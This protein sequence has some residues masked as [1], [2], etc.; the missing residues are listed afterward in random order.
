[1][2]R[3][4]QDSK[5]IGRAS[6]VL[7]AGIEK[8][9]RT[10]ELEYIKAERCRICGLD[11]SDLPH[12]THV[13][14]VI[15][16]ELMSNATYRGAIDA[17]EPFI[18][19]WP[20]DQRPTYAAVRNHAKRHLNRDQA[21]MRQLMETHAVNTGIDIEES[22]GPILTPGGVLA[23]IAQKGYEQVRDG[24][25]TPTIG[26]TI[27]ASRALI[28]IDRDALLAALEEERGRVRL[29]VTAL[30]EMSPGAPDSV[31]SSPSELPTGAG[32]SVI[33]LPEADASDPTSEEGMSGGY[34]CDECVTVAKTKRGLTQR[35]RWK[36]AD[37]SHTTTG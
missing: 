31:T 37:R 36:H 14:R 30:R 32:S 13:R 19:G 7:R 34:S 10:T 23:V 35:K 24:D 33:I 9:A 12:S 17:A 1:M 16:R 25:A 15:D 26:D 29:L 5:Q 28:A 20:P 3:R 21:L 27:A 18:A 8:A 4:T 22:E 6:E 2:D 11:R